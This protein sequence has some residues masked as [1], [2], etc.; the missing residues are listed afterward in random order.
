MDAKETA[1]A[2][3]KFEEENRASQDPIHA[4][5]D[6]DRTGLDDE[7]E[8]LPE[9]EKLELD[10]EG[11]VDQPDE[12]EEPTPDIPDMSLPESSVSVVGQANPEAS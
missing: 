5:L 11:D 9:D 2:L 7:S 8:D 1:A 10:A 4:P 6:I 3:K 12:E